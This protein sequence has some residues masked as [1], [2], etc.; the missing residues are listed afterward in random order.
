TLSYLIVVGL[1][2]A[3]I[4]GGVFEI[5]LGSLLAFLFGLVLVNAC[6]AYIYKAIKKEFL[7]GKTVMSAVKKGYGKTLWHVIDVYAVLLIGALVT[8]IGVGGLNVMASQLVICMITAAF[9]NLLWGRGINYV[10]LSA[11]KDK[12]KYFRFA[13]ED[14]ED[15]E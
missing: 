11:S 10:F 12:Y 8:L 14:D 9:C 13:R 2:F 1:C 4:S 5:T 6:N 15:E 3:F 7:S